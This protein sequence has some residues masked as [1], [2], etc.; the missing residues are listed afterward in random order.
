M[1]TR[2]IA[3][4]AA[5]FLGAACFNLEAKSFAGELPAAVI[6]YIETYFP[7]QPIDKAVK[8]F[9]MRSTWYEVDFKN[10]V[11]LKFNEAGE[12]LEMESDLALPDAALPANVVSYVKENYAGHYIVGWEKEKKGQEIELNDGTEL[13]FNKDGEFVREDD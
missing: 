7:A 5:L 13:K 6:E 4:A 2:S 1:N 9:D 8:E 10:G 12:I 3:C 11:E